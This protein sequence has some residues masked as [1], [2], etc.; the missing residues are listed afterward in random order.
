[1]KLGGVSLPRVGS[2][3]RKAILSPSV[4]GPYIKL[5]LCQ[6]ESHLAMVFIRYPRA[7]SERVKRAGSQGECAVIRVRVLWRCAL[8]CAPSK[9]DRR[10][11]TEPVNDTKLASLS[12][13]EQE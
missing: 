11:V 10:L 6:A 12:A 13:I 1:M 9:H 2:R 7:N 3:G 5:P 8:F 4:G